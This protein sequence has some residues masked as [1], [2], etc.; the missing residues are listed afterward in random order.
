LVV[1][2][3]PFAL[4]IDWHLIGNYCRPLA[5]ERGSVALFVAL[6]AREPDEIEEAVVSK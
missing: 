1:R 2:A 6:A 4:L 3:A 5:H